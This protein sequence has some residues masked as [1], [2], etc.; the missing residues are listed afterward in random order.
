MITGLFLLH[1]T[2]VSQT[3]IWR[4]R[5]GFQLRQKS[6]LPPRKFCRIKKFAPDQDERQLKKP[7]AQGL[8]MRLSQPHGSGALE[9]EN[10]EQRR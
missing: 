6:E 3:M 4:P 2:G 10:V 7:E 5:V 9:E 8:G 1:P